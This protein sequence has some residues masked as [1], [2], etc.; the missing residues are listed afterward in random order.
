MRVCRIARPPEAKPQHR[1]ATGKNG[2]PLGTTR[3]SW[4]GDSQSLLKFLRT[5]VHQMRQKAKIGGIR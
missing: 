4:D 3:T 5:T 1:V 2:E